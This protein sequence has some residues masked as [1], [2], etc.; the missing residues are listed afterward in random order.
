MSC[1]PRLSS[2]TDAAGRSRPGCERLEG[3]R[4]F[5]HGADRSEG[6]LVSRSRASHHF[7]AGASQLA[8]AAPCSPCAPTHRA[9]SSSHYQ[10]LSVAGLA[11]PPPSSTSRT[12]TDGAGLT[13]RSSV[14]YAK[15][16]SVQLPHRTDA[17]LLLHDPSA[18]ARLSAVPRNYRRLRLSAYLG[19][20]LAAI[21]LV[22]LAARDVPVPGELS[23][24]RP[25][26][27]GVRPSSWRNAAARVRSKAGAASEGRTARPTAAAGASA[28][29]S[30]TAASAASGESSPVT[31]VSSFYRV[32]SGKKHRVSG[33]SS[34]T[35]S[36]RSS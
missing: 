2:S 13:R 22:A 1:G 20:S 24:L 25:L 19:W 28:H 14:T 33:A 3:S 15:R 23:D 26:G 31:I 21:L 9:M 29:T 10:A 35:S 5:G 30:A 27:G 8:Q 17:G 7:A 4:P 32:D 12:S 18:R 11:D 6:G 36:P 34:Y 16:A